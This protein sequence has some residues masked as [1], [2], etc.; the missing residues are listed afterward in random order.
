MPVVVV[1]WDPVMPA[2]GGQRLHEVQGWNDPD[3]LT[4]QLQDALNNGS[5]GAV[6]YHVART[7]RMDTFP[8]KRDG[9][10][11]DERGYLGAIASKQWHQPDDASYFMTFQE[12]GIAQAMSETGAR[13]VWIWGAP[14]FGWDE[15]AF[16]HPN[17][18][19][20]Y[21]STNV[22]FYRPYD[23]PDLGTT[24]W[25]MGL[26]YERGPAEATHSY[27][28]RVESMLS[29]NLGRG[30]WD[31]KT[32]PDNV[33]TRF[34]L[35]GKDGQG[36]VGCGGVHVPPNGTTDYDYANET[37]I[38]SACDDWLDYPNLTGATT[39][40]TAE[41]WGGPD[42]QLGYLKWWLGHIP[43]A[44]GT[45]DGFHDDWWRYIADYDAAVAALPPPGGILQRPSTARYADPPP[46]CGDGLACTSDL[47]LGA[48]PCRQSADATS[49]IYCCAPGVS[50]QGGTCG[51]DPPPAPPP[52]PP[53][54]PGPPTCGDIGGALCEWNGNGACGGVG[55][56]TSDC[57]HCCGG[58]VTGGATCG[59]LGGNTCEWNG[60][61]ACGGVGAPTSDC[62]ACCVR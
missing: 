23:L 29:L 7:I 62:D 37:P 35:T 22:W 5:G 4:G 40:V 50:P 44:D 38:D 25:V 61:G 53:P 2:H 20:Y 48:T 36:Y 27:G 13:E 31:P 33:W 45:T 21:G 57:A 60:N 52:D 9:F 39:T 14:A 8:V 12:A 6:S 30:V 28:H 17:D 41:T 32:N 51:G 34:T 19:T 56:G 24:Y 49:A 55:P 16:K 46:V 10:R 1:V 15:F 3:V 47:T 43:R 18:Q 42:Y 59:D 58:G 54:P 26:S 11:Y